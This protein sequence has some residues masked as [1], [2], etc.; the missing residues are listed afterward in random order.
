MD[1]G[2]FPMISPKIL[3]DCVSVHKSGTLHHTGVPASGDRYSVTIDPEPTIFADGKRV[4]AAIAVKGIAFDEE[5]TLLV[6]AAG[7]AV[8]EL[9]D[10]LIV[11]HG[12]V[13]VGYEIILV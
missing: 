11:G 9:V 8:D 6:F 13:G 1:R 3:K 2:L 5:R 12:S 4:M 10:D 7:C